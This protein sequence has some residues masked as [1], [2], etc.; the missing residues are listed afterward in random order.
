VVRGRIGVCALIKCYECEKEI[1]DKAPACPHCGA[2][3]EEQPPQIEEAEI[4]ES[5]ATVDEPD[6]MIDRLEEEDD[7][8]LSHLTSAEGLKLPEH[9]GG[10]LHLSGLTTADG[11]KLPWYVNRNLDLSGLTTAE[12]L[13]LPEHVGGDIDCG[14]PQW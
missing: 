2:P 10:Y 7:L 4:L 5:V 11:L 6:A 13:K 9:V 3:K 14:R 1:S 8:N 12:G